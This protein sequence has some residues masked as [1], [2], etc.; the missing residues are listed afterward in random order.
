MLPIK[1]WTLYEKNMSTVIFHPLPKTQMAL[2]SQ[3]QLNF[4]EWK[5]VW[6]SNVINIVKF[7][8]NC[9]IA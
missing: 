5:I 8:T 9:F 1:S 4:R 3:A 2:A 6:K 7:L